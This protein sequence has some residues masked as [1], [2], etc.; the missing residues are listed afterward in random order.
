[1]T[2]YLE[3]V[4]PY[5]KKSKNVSSTRKQNVVLVTENSS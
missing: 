4:V 2:L 3:F 5:I 1:M